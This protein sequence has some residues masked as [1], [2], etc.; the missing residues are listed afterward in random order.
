MHSDVDGN[1]TPNGG[2]VPASLTVTALKPDVTVLDE[3]K[4]SFEILEL[5]VPFEDNIHLRHKQKADKYAHFI[6]DITKHKT[7]VTAFEIGARGHL[8]KDNTDRLKYISTRSP[9]R[10]SQGTHSSTTAVPWRY[11]AATT[12]SL[13]GRSP[14]GPAL[15]SSHLP[16]RTNHNP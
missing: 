8:T 2:T 15:A 6:T 13:Q 9:P 4:K 11:R 7:T 5:T 12:S 3:N 10:R 14:P 16:S 1:K